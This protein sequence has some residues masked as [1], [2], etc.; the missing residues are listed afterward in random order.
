MESRW[1]IWIGIAGVFLAGVSIVNSIVF[2]S[3]QKKSAEAQN[4]IAQQSADV[5]AVQVFQAFLPNLQS[6]DAQAQKVYVF[7]AE[8]F[9]TT[10]NNTLFAE[11][12]LS[13]DEQQEINLD[14]T[15][16]FQLV[17]TTSEF[18]ESADMEKPERWTAV[19]HSFKAT[20]QELAENAACVLIGS[21]K[22]QWPSSMIKPQIEIYLTKISNSLAVTVGGFVTKDIATKTVGI[23]RDKGIKR[24]AFVQLDRD[25]ELK[26]VMGK[27]LLSVKCS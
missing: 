21:I 6:G 7:I 27:T 22:R 16:K 20:N 4:E 10:H 1:S 11:L 3:Y 8:R 5:S 17:E 2:F 12:I 14:A 19:A 25:W 13:L 24:D 18:D 9:K 26:E 15:T 23:L